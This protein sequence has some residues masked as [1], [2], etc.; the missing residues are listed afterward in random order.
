MMNLIT[1]IFV[2][3]MCTSATY[4]FTPSSHVNVP[5]TL[6]TSTT[7]TSK[8][9]LSMTK[10]QEQEGP[11]DFL[12]G[13]FNNKDNTNQIKNELKPKLPDK[14]I[15]PDYNIAIAFA[16]VGIL[17]VLIT[18]ASIYGCVQGGITLLF[19]SFLAVQ[20]T[21]IRFIFDETSFE[22]KMGGDNLQSSGENIVVGGENRWTYDSFVN[23]EFFPKRGLPILVYFKENQTPEEMWN[24]GPGSLDKKGGGQLHFFPAIAN[25]EQ[26]K[27]QFELRGCA[28]VVEE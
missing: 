28:K 10:Q 3:L 21:R 16:V 24:V 27:E 19:S 22:L 26:L 11:F 6:V 8:F 5:R 12:S 4:A 15:D 18:Q 7:S 14:V 20:A 13:L 9:V 25:V 2:T 23:W 17:I 1:S